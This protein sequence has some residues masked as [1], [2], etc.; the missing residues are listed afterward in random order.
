MAAAATAGETLTSLVIRGV[1]MVRLVGAALLAVELGPDAALTALGGDH[2]RPVDP[3]RPMAH[4][5]CVAALEI[6][7]PIVPLV[8]VKSYDPSL[9]VGCR[10]VCP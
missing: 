9:H 3:R 5:L 4:M 10:Y 7:H 1:V 8:L 6:G 2:P